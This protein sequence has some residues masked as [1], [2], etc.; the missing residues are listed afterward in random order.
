ARSLLAEELGLDPGPALVELEGAILGQRIDVLRQAIGAPAATLLA[1]ARQAGAPAQVP[2]VPRSTV[3]EP[4]RPSAAEPDSAS[5]ITFIGRERELAELR[6]L[7]RRVSAGTPAIALLA[8]EA[9]VGKSSLLD[10]LSDDLT[11]QGWL[12]LTGRC[13]ETE[14]APPAWAW[15]AALRDLAR[16]VPPA[17]LAAQLAPLLSAGEA[18]GADLDATTGRFRL[19]AAVSRWLARAAAQRPL[20]LVIDDLHDADSETMSLLTSVA[21]GLDASATLL[22]TA[23]RPAEGQPRLVD[24]L[25]A[26]ARLHPHRLNLAGFGPAEVERLVSL[27]CGEPVDHD[28]ARLLTERT[29]GNPFYVR[30]S[31]RLLAAEGAL[32]AISEV[33]EG[34]RDVLRRRTARLPPAA[35]S[36]L[37]LAAVVGREAEVDILLAAADTDEGGVLDACEAGLIAGLLDEPAPGRVRFVHALVRDTM[38]TDLSLLRRARMHARVADALRAL[39]PD[40]VSALAHHY[41]HAAGAGAAALAV[42]Y[43]VRAAALAQRRYA[44]DAE[45][46][47]LR[48]ALHSLTRGSAAEPDDRDTREVDLLGQL[49]RAQVRAGAVAAARE[50]RSR[51]IELAERAGRADLLVA[52]FT[53]WTE[54]TPW[55][56]HRYGAFDD[57]TVHTLDAL[58][59]RPGL[60][61]ADRCRLLTAL[62]SELE[63]SSDP[64]IRA[65][66]AEAVALARDVGDPA[67]VAQALSA[68]LRATSSDRDPRLWAEVGTEIGAL[69]TEHDLPA[70]RW[71]AEHV[72][73]R[74]A[75]AHNDVPTVRECLARG[76]SVARSYQ[77]TEAESVTL[78]AD[79]MFDHIEGRLAEAGRRYQEVTELM[80]RHGSLH[81]SGF[82]AM[83]QA[84]VLISAGRLGELLP[85]MLPMLPDYPVAADTVA[86][87]LAQAGDTGRAREIRR[88]AHA[89]PVD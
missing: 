39:R 78:S 86:L 84:T 26:L 10:R 52:A 79:P 1:E 13:P 34:V 45:V 29:G 28:T 67:L 5:A 33:P 47:L 4:V 15:V 74:V 14:D 72:A 73:A 41:A 46:S 51:A 65:S 38:Y 54:P 32:V 19:H 16:V 55:L 66:A 60:A 70:Y 82:A 6:S 11:G 87:A 62:S 37:R 61:V 76:L 88:G 40:D 83:A 35:V 64:R 80:V 49:L 75:A 8:G 31:A 2:Q 30:E 21:T 57:R 12:V 24:T 43:S 71:Y 50:T 27:V 42:E 69:A 22:V 44:H 59:R 20:A 53:A 3:V 68:M 25:A 81:A 7:A 58:L 36:V 85:I 77:L 56:V 9:G 23:F 63:G 89:L 17:D 48:Q 18:A